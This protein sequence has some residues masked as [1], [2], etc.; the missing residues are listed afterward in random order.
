MTCQ[1]SLPHLSLK[2]KIEGLKTYSTML[3]RHPAS[4]IHRRDTLLP[5][6]SRIQTG[7][8]EESNQGDGDD[9]GEQDPA[10]PVTPARV[11]VV[12]VVAVAVVLALAEEA[13]HCGA[14]GGGESVRRWEWKG[15]GGHLGCVWMWLG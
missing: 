2:W 8:E 6:P 5:A 15:E 12:V 14:R 9:D 1:Q 7:D 3:R 11:A 13:G 4:S 10:T